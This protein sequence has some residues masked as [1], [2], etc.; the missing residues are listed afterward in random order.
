MSDWRENLITDDAEILAIARGA[1]RVAVLG[2]KP[3]SHGGQPAHY[4]PAY[5]AGAGV[6]VI[7][8]PVYYPEVTEILGRPVHRD[9]ASVPG[10]IDIFDVFR[11]PAD[12]PPHV[13]D[14]IAARP[15]C[16]WLQLG[17]RHDEAAERL[18]RAGVRV[19]QDRCLLVDHRRAVGGQR[20]A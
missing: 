10:P 13:D 11:R 1:R 20:G 8:V 15:A 19:V 16:V 18:A 14:L 17:I 2:I 5:L 12:V 6:E 7:P 4:V 9:V 3:E